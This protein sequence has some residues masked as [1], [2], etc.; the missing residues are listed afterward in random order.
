MT[1]ISD[2]IAQS[3]GGLAQNTGD[4]EPAAFVDDVHGGSPI[5]AYVVHTY[6]PG[7]FAADSQ[8]YPASP[9]VQF[10]LAISRLALNG[11]AA[12]LQATKWYQGNWNEAGLGSDGGG[13][14]SPIFPHLNNTLALYKHCLAP[15]QSRSS[16]SISYSDITNEY[17]LLFVC[18][19]PT[20]PQ[21]ETAYQSGSV[22]GGAWFYAT[23]DA[24]AYDLSHQD[25]W[26]IPSEVAN[27]WSPFAQNGGCVQDF[28]GWYPDLMSI[29][30]KPGHLGAQGYAFY[31]NGCTGKETT[32]GRVY[33]TRAFTIQTQ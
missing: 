2:A 16:A 7:P 21:T 18:L 9:E 11:G 32:S 28:N 6:N 14:E 4:S 22:T 26:S 12:R 25:Q 17:V 24:T 10:D 13:H 27:S 19:S 33:S 30:A 15:S 29:G 3:A 20:E 31:M 1:T 23:I 5:Y 8:L